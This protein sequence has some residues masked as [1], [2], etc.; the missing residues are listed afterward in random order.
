MAAHCARKKKK[1]TLE[2]QEKPYKNFDF[3]KL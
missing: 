2:E 1:E 3:T